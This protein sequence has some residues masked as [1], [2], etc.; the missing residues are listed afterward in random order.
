M[1]LTFII[2]SII[3]YTLLIAII[4]ITYQKKQTTAVI[5][6]FWS[7]GHWLLGSWMLYQNS[8][9]N[10]H[11]IWVYLCLTAWAFRLS[12]YIYCTRVYQKHLE[13]RYDNL[14][15]KQNQSF[16][17]QFLKQITLQV[18][19][20]YL[21]MAPFYLTLLHPVN[22]SFYTACISGLLFIFGFINEALTDWQRHKFRKKNHGILTT[23][24]WGLSR[25]P[26]Y[27]FELMMW[28]AFAVMAFDQSYG[29]ITLLSPVIL[30]MIML[31]IT[32]PVTEQYA[33]KK[34]PELYKAYQ[35][36]TNK[37]L[38]WIKRSN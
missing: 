27:F 18:T 24:W 31:K 17:H 32:I 11:N 25:H 28:Y 10:T 33:L 34:N 1:Y 26:N 8:A 36:N 6:A 13:P 29:W 35:H 12:G 19:L 22:F 5:D 30:N 2:G 21:L 7:L 3:I 37:L 4:Y 23:G 9:M 15:K 20:I 38:P 16:N 14:L